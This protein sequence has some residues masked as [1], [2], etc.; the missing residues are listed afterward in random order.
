[1]AKVGFK[2]VWGGFNMFVRVLWRELLGNEG[3]RW[4]GGHMGI[5]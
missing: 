1:M 4:K 2:C 3:V 5:M